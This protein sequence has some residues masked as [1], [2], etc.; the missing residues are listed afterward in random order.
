MDLWHTIRRHAQQRHREAT[1]ASGGS[2]QAVDLIRQ[3]CAR[4]GLS[5]DRLP[6][7]HPEL[8]GA[9]GTLDREWQCIKIATGLS[10]EDEAF[11]IAHELGHFWLHPDSSLCLAADFNQE[12][13]EALRPTGVQRVEGYSPHERKEVQANI[14]AQEFLCPSDALRHRALVEASRPADIAHALGLPTGLVFQQLTRAL[15]LPP[16]PHDDQHAEALDGV[17]T[18]NEEQ[19]EAAEVA[20][21]PYL[22][23][24]GPGTGKTKTLIARMLFLL[25]QHVPPSH[26]LALTFSNKAAEEIR[27]RIARV[28]PQAAPQLWIGTFHAFGLELLYKWGAHLGLAQDL[29]VVDESAALA[30]LERQLPHLQLQHYQNLYDP[31]LQLRY[32][33]RAIFRAKDELIR[34]AQYRARAQTMLDQATDEAIR[35]AAQA[36]LEVAQVFEV[37]QEALR[38]AGAVDFADLVQLAVELLEQHPKVRASVRQTYP[39]VLVDEYQDVNRASGRL[40]QAVA[41]EGH[42]LWVVADARQSIYRFRGA[43]PTNVT[44]FTEDFPTARTTP[45]WRNYRSGTPVVRLFT[46]FATTMHA[47]QNRPV[48]WHAERGE[49]GEVHYTEAPDLAAEAA[50]LAAHIERY[51]AAGI[52]YRDQAILGRS[53]LTLARFAD[54]LQRLGIPVLYLG[55]LFERPEIRDLLS[56][57]SIDAEPGGIGVVRVA[58]F[59][60]YRV[61]RPDVLTLLAWAQ[62]N[63]LTVMAALAQVNQV[64][65]LT[66]AGRTGLA[67]L[68][69]HLE[70]FGPHTSPWRMLTTY[71][72]E[73]SDYL[74]PLCLADDPQSQQRL[75]AIFQLLEFCQGHAAPAHPLAARRELLDAIRRLEALDED[76]LFREVPMGARHLN[77]VPMLTIHASK[78]LE[79]PVVHLPALATRYTP[80]SRR[81]SRC[82]PPAGLEHLTMDQADHAAEE[83]SLFFVALSRAQNVLSLSRATR[84]TRQNSSPSPFLG[85]LAAV[86]PPPQPAPVAP[87][88]ARAS[89]AWEPQEPKPAY[90]ARDLEIYANCPAQYRYEVVDGLR[91]PRDSLAYVRFHRCVYRVIHWMEQQ[92]N[93]GQ[94]VRTPLAL[95]QLELAWQQAG[96]VGHGFEPYYR[97]MA[98][99]MVAAMVTYLAEELGEPVRA[100]WQ[101]EINGR[102]VTLT[103]DRIVLE[104]DGS[105]RVQRLRTGRKTKAEPNKELYGLY[106][107]GARARYPNRPLQLETLYLGTQ[108]VVPVDVQ[109]EAKRLQTYAEAMAG[110]ERGDFTPSPDAQ[111]CPSCQFY[112]ICTSETPT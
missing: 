68:Q 54:A 101:V 88:V 7:H 79:F 100:E 21:G 52:A 4:A 62:E 61:A 12:A 71:L 111:R 78:G 47:G 82:P 51:N 6:P 14:F 80:A 106:A 37:Y 102:I 42:R 65:G 10:P 39:H 25:A 104:P 34:P 69:R 66:E 67:Q 48:P 96:P 5:L 90:P 103:P 86:L 81:S 76:R 105:V 64:D 15:L 22:L 1:Q 31:A 83:E 70:G 57:L 20:E 87:A 26:L 38:Q 9:T 85:T 73:R 2:T 56:L 89:P 109:D 36:T 33:L 11:C 99:E 30:L 59:P 18:L 110:I 50:A 55:D 97:R 49:V 92:C 94:P 108:E 58:Q 43:T 32:V 44:R 74:R 84:Y 27:T 91:G 13:D 40:L 72:F 28:A 17:V 60:E 23:D 93:A 75:L 8:A 63:N 98:E 41:G 24:A 46:H 112:F 19:R 107:A 95:A 16:L 3:A 35:A 53:H 77:A 45:L 29:H